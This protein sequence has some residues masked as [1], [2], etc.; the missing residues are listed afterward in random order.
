MAG[1]T[2]RSDE[3]WAL[4]GRELLSETAFLTYVVLN[5]ELVGGSYIPHNNN[6]SLY[7]VGV[8]RRDLVELNLG[9]IS[10]WLA[11]ENL[12]KLGIS[13]YRLG[14]L[15]IGQKSEATLKEQSI[16]HFKRGFA[17]EVQTEHVFSF[18]DTLNAF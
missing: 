10:Q 3:T 1:R 12:N 4:Q 13:I 9:H 16:A 2:T 8:Y 6:N 14:H 15:D 17:S 11:I 5:H 7:A 18:G